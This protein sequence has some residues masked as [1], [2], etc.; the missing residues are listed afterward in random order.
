LQV[1]RGPAQNF[2]LDRPL[3]I[4]VHDHG[5]VEHRAPGA[6]PTAA[7][8]VDDR[9]AVWA[10]YA[11]MREWERTDSAVT[12]VTSVQFGLRGRLAHV[13]EGA[14]PAR[15]GLVSALGSA[16]LN[17][18]PMSHL[19]MFALSAAEAGA[20]HR[21]VLAALIGGDLGPR[22]IPMGSLAGLLWLETLRRAGVSISARRFLV[23][24]V[25]A[26]APALAVSLA[27]V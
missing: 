18:H 25:L 6:D 3:A 21:S 4:A 17:N 2:A 11:P 1:S 27:L 23:V 22:L 19:N 10:E 5:V 9:P 15:I 7:G 16:V 14:P 12:A 26:T 24:G 20:A 8:L 13:Y